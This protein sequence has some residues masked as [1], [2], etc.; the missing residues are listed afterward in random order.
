MLLWTRPGKD[1]K[2]WSRAFKKLETAQNTS[3]PSLHWLF[4]TTENTFVMSLFQALIPAPLLAFEDVLNGKSTGTVE[5]WLS[6]TS[7][8]RPE[9][10]MTK[11]F[12]KAYTVLDLKKKL[13]LL[14]DSTNGEVA[15]KIILKDRLCGFETG[16]MGRIY[17]ERLV[18]SKFDESHLANLSLPLTF[19]YPFA[20]FF[21]DGEIVLFWTSS[22]EDLAMWSDVL[23]K[24]LPPQTES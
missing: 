3:E 24:L 4:Q 11:P 19:L 2:V 14:C 13:L 9:N 8:K 6:K 5:G 7:P 20:L 15:E 23:N 10:L 16:I 21:N 17:M 22:K 1:F 18:S 12:L